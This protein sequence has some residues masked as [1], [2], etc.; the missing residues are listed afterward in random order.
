ML[1]KISF[2][3]FK[4]KEIE[5]IENHII[6]VEPLWVVLRFLAFDNKDQPPPHNRHENRLIL[7]DS[8]KVIPL[9][10]YM[11]PESLANP[12][13]QLTFLIKAMDQQIIAYIKLSVLFIKIVHLHWHSFCFIPRFYLYSDTF[14]WLFGNWLLLIIMSLSII[15]ILEM[16][17]RY[18]DPV[19]Q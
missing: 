19:H 2:S 17:S 5:I 3:I 12:F 15:L 7:V 16:Y 13:S 10:L 11:S 1:Q 8:I 14:V 18:F 6:L 9:G 4:T